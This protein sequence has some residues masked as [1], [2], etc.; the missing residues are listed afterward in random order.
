[1]K[2]KKPIPFNF[3]LEELDP[4]A[5]YT[6]PMFGCTAIYVGNKIVL[7]L[8]Q[9]EPTDKDSGIWLATTQEH[10]ESLKKDFPVSSKTASVTGRGTGQT[11]SM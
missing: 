6:R 11:A 7:I 2:K 4:V 3:V 9:K 8:R 1:M 10:H 5:P